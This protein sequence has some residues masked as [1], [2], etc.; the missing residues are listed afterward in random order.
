MGK[1]ALLNAN[2]ELERKGIRNGYV[3]VFYYNK[4]AV[5]SQKHA[6]RQ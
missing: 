2:A 4:D 3:G 5:G 1:A 6:F